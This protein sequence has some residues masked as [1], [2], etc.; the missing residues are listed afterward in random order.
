MA[1]IPLLHLLF[2]AGMPS[3]P[4]PDTLFLHPDTCDALGTTLAVAALD[5]PVTRRRH[6]IQYSDWYNR[7]LTIHRIGSYTMLP[8]FAA[9]WSLGQNLLQDRERSTWMLD[10]HQFVAGAIGVLFTVNTVT[11][12]WNL[13]DSRHDPAGRTRRI[14]H[15]ALML[16]S[17]AGFV[18]TGI[19][20]NSAG[21]SR[22]DA[23]HH[24]A[25]ALSSIGLSTAGTLMMWF[26]KD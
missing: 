13:W 3:A 22:T 24:R 10:T 4:P 5:T 14:L 17:D 11:G 12:A 9:E 19:A 7:R 16:G 26:W 15:A 6:A 21:R 25:I 1:T 2:F 23:D 8:L 18:W 20:A